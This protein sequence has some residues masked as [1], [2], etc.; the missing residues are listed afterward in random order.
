MFI[1]SSFSR[2]RWQRCIRTSVTITCIVGRRKKAYQLESI[3]A[4]MKTDLF[5]SV[6]SI[7]YRSR[8]K[9]QKSELLDYNCLID[10]TFFVPKVFQDFEVL[11]GKNFI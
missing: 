9:V 11:I 3:S 4:F 8:H 6:I 7:K 2:S 1:H 10:G 5:S